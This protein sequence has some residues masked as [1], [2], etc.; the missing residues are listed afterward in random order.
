MERRKRILIVDDHPVNI[1]LLEECLEDVYDLVVATTGEDALA[2]VGEVCPDL[3]LLD[4]MMP[5]IDGYETCRRL[6][7]MPLLAHIPIIFVSA[8]A[9]ASEQR[10]GYT[11]GGNDYLTKPFTLEHLRAVIENWLPR[12]VEPQTSRHVDPT[13]GT[14]SRDIQISPLDPKVLNSLETLLNGDTHFASVLRRYLEIASTCVSQLQQAVELADRSTMRQAADHLKYSSTIVGAMRLAEQCQEVE[15]W[16]NAPRTSTSFTQLEGEWHAVRSELSERLGR[17]RGDASEMAGA[18]MRSSTEASVDVAT[19]LI[20]DDEPIN[21]QVCQGILAP[22]GHRLLTASNGYEAFEVMAQDPPDV[23]LLDLMMPEMDG[24]EICQRLKASP[25]WQSLPII[26]LTALHEAADYVRALDCGADDFLSKPVNAAMLKAC[27]RNVLRRKRAEDAL[28]SAKA[29]ADAANQAKSMFLANMSHELRTP[30]H[31][32]LSC[33]SF[34]HKRIDTESPTKL[35]TYFQKIEESGQSL[36]V[37]I[38][39]L[40]DLA[41]LEAGK[42][43]F[44]FEPMAFQP[45]LTQVANEFQTLLAERQM[46]LKTDMPD[47]PLELLLDPDKIRQ[48]LRNLLSNAVKFSPEGGTITCC[49]RAEPDT[50]VLHVSDEGPGIPAEELEAIFDKFIQSNKTRTGAGGTGL[51]LAICREIVAAHSGHIWAENRSEGGAVFCLTFSA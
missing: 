35:Q 45:L 50:V 30:I 24:F 18:A 8:K 21:L 34:G 40:L 32:L 42:V 3:I 51:G 6:R 44:T 31:V 46:T 14:L 33:A 23:L 48:V 22:L 5:G 49:L 36:L 11:A 38:N 19:L 10:Q 13:F 20:V 43:A 37:L 29:S 1:E 26:A 4:V 9:F 16:G 27:V 15:A 7:Q 39:D 41:K 25:Q 28:Q 47:T 2:I 17:A 12:R